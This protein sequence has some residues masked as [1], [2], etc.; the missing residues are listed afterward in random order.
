MEVLLDRLTDQNPVG[1]E[2]WALKTKPP[3]CQYVWGLVNVNVGWKLYKYMHFT[4][5]VFALTLMK[6]CSGKLYVM[7]CKH[8]NMPPAVHHMI[9]NHVG[10]DVAIMSREFEE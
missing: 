4:K 3:P 7:D 2:P 9:C 8:N 1:D 10:L 5:K 6:M